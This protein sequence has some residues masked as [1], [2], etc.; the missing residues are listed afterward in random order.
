MH[1]TFQPGL[2]NLMP[3]LTDQHPG[4]CSVSLLRCKSNKIGKRTPFEV[5]NL[6]FHY[7]VDAQAR[8]EAWMEHLT[9]NMT[10]LSGIEWGDG[11]R[12][13]EQFLSCSAVFIDFDDGMPRI[14]DLLARLSGEAAGFIYTTKSHQKHKGKH[15]PC[16]RYRLV[17]P[18]S[19]AIA[20]VEEYKVFT[21]ALLQLVFPEADHQLKSPAAYVRGGGEDTLVY[22]FGGTT[23]ISVDDVLHLGKARIPDLVPV[24]KRKRRKTQVSIKISGKANGNIVRS[25]A[26]VYADTSWGKADTFRQMYRMA[27]EVFKHTLSMEEAKKA[28]LAW[29][30]CSSWLKRH[31]NQRGSFDRMLTEC[32][33]AHLAESLK[34]YTEIRPPNEI[35]TVSGADLLPIPNRFQRRLNEYFAAFHVEEDTL[36]WGTHRLFHWSMTNETHRKCILAVPCGLH[37]STSLTC[38]AAEFAGPENRIWIVK[39]T[40]DDCITQR[41]QLLRIG[42]ECVGL[43]A[44]FR[45]QDCQLGHRDLE[46]HRMYSKDSSPCNECPFAEACLFGTTLL[47]KGDQLAKDIV[48]MTHRRY[49]MMNQAHLIPEDVTIVVDEALAVSESLSLSYGEWASLEE[50]IPAGVSTHRRHV[51]TMAGDHGCHR[52]GFMLAPAKAREIQAILRSDSRVLSDT[53]RQLLARYTDFFSGEARRFV[54][55]NG[56]SLDWVKSIVYNDLPNRVLYLDGSAEYSAVEWPGFT[57]YTLSEHQQTNFSNLTL[58]AHMANP[59]KKKMKDDWAQFSKMIQNF[60]LKEPEHSI[61]L[62]HNKNADVNFKEIQDLQSFLSTNVEGGHVSLPRGKITGS[63]AARDCD[64]AIVACSIFTS[65]SDYVLRCALVEDRDITWDRIWDKDINGNLSPKMCRGFCDEGIDLAFRRQ[66]AEELYQT[67]MRIRARSYKNQECHVFAFISDYWLL[68]ELS[69]ILRNYRL[70]GNNAVARGF[71][72]LEKLS[73][74]EL[75]KISVRKLY[76]RLGGNTNKDGCRILRAKRDFEWR[77]RMRETE[78][79]S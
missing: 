23:T 1:S 76:K 47:H 38:W 55:K 5:R 25:L 51:E 35:V 31:P 74:A 54:V 73:I 52:D 77:K 70:A 17:M 28:L 44:G 39:P 72:A 11:R 10:V 40:V 18:L 61:F 12:C 13:G 57:I 41:K 56:S 68:E 63:N 36:S 43:L 29:D 58:H 7:F 75:E 64:V 6:G 78:E 33:E 16:D 21:G 20:T 60:L 48:V 8:D 37:K 26:K 67:L 53:H 15:G 50:L 65:V 66:Y 79:A 4:V 69:R 3:V 2:H 71:R 9:S 14:S 59:T 24:T 46:W 34:Q 32:R 49:Q 62:G 19:R 45:S 42:T 30:M 27:I 22:W